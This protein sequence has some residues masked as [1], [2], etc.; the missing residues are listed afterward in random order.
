[1]RTPGKVSSI[2]Q[3]P[4]TRVRASSTSTRFPARAR[5]AAQA[6]PLWPAPAITTSQRRE[7]KS[8]TGAGNPISPRTA[9]VGEITFLVSTTERQV[10]KWAHKVRIKACECAGADLEYTVR[11]YIGKMTF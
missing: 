3:A 9:A 7:A 1:M 10:G 5:Y 6:R 8:R 2:V 4:P 11:N